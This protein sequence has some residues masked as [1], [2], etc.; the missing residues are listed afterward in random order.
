MKKLLNLLSVLTISGTAVPTTI[1]A[2]PYQK[3]ETINSDINYQQIN[4]LENLIRNK[5]DV[6]S[7]IWNSTLGHLVSNSTVYEGGTFT[8]EWRPIQVAYWKLK[9]DNAACNVILNKW[10]S[11]GADTAKTAL[12]AVVQGLF[13]AGGIGGPL[14]TLAAASLAVNFWVIKAI[15]ENNNNGNGVWIGFWINQPG[16]GFGSL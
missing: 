6:F 3:E 8:A 2:S 4:N 15:I 12:M 10:N 13:A 7:D 5:R 14:G 11:L 1:A 16:V 9:M